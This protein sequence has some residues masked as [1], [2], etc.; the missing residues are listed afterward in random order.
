VKSQA[1][2][3]A[4]YDLFPFD[5][6][7]LWQAIQKRELSYEQ[8]IQAEVQHWIRTRAG[9]VLRENAMKMAERL[10]PAIFQQLMETYLEECT[11]H[12]TGPSHLRLIE[13]L[14][15]EGGKSMIDLES[16]VPTPGNAAAIALYRDISSRGAGCHLVGAGA[17]EHYY[18]RLAPKIFAAYTEHYGMS[19]SQAFTY[20]VHGPMD[21]IHADRA[22]SVLDEA[23]ALHGWDAVQ[24]SV[25]DAFVA[26]SLHYDGMLQGATGVLAYWD[27][28]KT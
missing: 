2:L 27:G 17:V 26:T 19:E 22:F 13:R 1:Q 12:H 16:T 5:H 28:R 7:P 4:L 21:Q 18:C 25:R 9:R 11:D 15:T 8:V 23:I 3:L 6:H 20:K 14:V 10:S 24:Q